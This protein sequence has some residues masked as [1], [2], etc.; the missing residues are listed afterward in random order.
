VLENAWHAILDSGWS[1][2][3]GLKVS[4]RCFEK[5]VDRKRPLLR[6]GRSTLSDYFWRTSL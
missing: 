1:A 3:F 4:R 6:E 5:T 2:Q